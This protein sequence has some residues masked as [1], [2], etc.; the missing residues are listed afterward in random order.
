MEK[1]QEFLSQRSST[2]EL[3]FCK[4]ISA[5]REIDG[6]MSRGQRPNE[7]VASSIPKPTSAVLDPAQRIFGESDQVLSHD[8]Q[9]LSRDRKG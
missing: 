3:W 1:V 8:R 4:T 7:M 6:K 9:S 5:I 2:G